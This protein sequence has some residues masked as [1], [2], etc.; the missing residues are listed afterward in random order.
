M[1]M[2]EAVGEDVVEAIYGHAAELMRNGV[3]DEDIIKDLVEQGLD[4][5]SAEVVVANLA[6]MRNEQQ[7]KAAKKNMGLGALWA[8]GG[9]V[10]TAAT[11]GAASGGGHYVVAWGAIAFGAI[12]FF[13]GLAQYSKVKRELVES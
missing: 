5:E 13:Q 12:Q 10:V 6:D 7:Q 1:G 9:T 4:A 3:K 8:V 2:S 11:Y